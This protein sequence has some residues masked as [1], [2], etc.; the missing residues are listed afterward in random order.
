MADTVTVDTSEL[1][2]WERVL[3]RAGVEIRKVNEEALTKAAKQLKADAQRD[4]PVRSGDLQ[5]SIRISAG[6]EFRRVGSNLRYAKFVELGTVNTAAQPYLFSN[7]EKA[8]LELTR[9]MAKNGENVI[10]KPR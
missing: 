8:G 10:L 7:A 1:D 6:K 9:E 5:R 2:R 3:A 4:V